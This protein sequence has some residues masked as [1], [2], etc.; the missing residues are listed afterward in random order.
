M[1]IH[2]KQ[3]KKNE[4]ITIRIEETIGPETEFDLS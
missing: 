4:S 2:K 1:K 3:F